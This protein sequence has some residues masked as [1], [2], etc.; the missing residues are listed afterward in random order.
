MSR[1]GLQETLKEGGRGMSGA[2][3]RAQ[4][5]FV[6]IEMAMAL[7]LLA[8][9]GLMVRSMAA[10]WSVDPGINPHNLI[11]FDMS[12]PSALATN[13]QAQRTLI[14]N[15]HDTLKA[16]PG[17]QYASMQG[18]GLPLSGDSSSLP[19][20]IE[21][22]PKPASVDDMAFAVFYIVEPEYLRAM[23]TPLLRGRFVSEQDNE[24]SPLVVVIDEIFARKY[25]ANEDPIGKRLNL[26][27]LDKQAE[28]VGV[29]AHV[30]HWGLD[31]DASSRVQVQVYFPL[32]QIP[33]KFMPL[34]A[35]GI[36]LVARTQGPPGLLADPIRHT[37]AGMSSEQVVYNVL[38]MEQV[39]ADSLAARRFTMILLG[40]FAG[41]ALMLASVGIYGVISYIV[42]QRTHEIGIR[43]ALGAQRG[44]VL[45]LV[46][47]QGVVMAGVGVGIGLAASFG[48]TRLM[49]QMIFGVTA[50]DPVTLAGVSLLLTA[51]ALLACY[52]PARRAMRTDP[53]VALRYE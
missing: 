39:V 16:I 8:G 34:V 35:N 10:L 43:M 23:G 1:A 25:F 27:I 50:T 40:V 21:G 6:A 28:I 7:V 44:D 47:G 20:W 53:V 45:K 17:V 33:D 52:V 14:R 51:V 48:L 15:I 4:S 46:L 18:G 41:L 12:M 11:S 49:K 3:Q 26:G 36:G 24:H 19:F 37:M 31:S 2:R 29:A 32:M 5:V 22:Q 9:A 30:K 38:T 13:P 42:G